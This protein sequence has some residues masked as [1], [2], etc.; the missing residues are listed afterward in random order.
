MPLSRRLARLGWIT[1]WKLASL[2]NRDRFREYRV[3]GHAIHLNVSESLMMYQIARGEYESHKLRVLDRLLEGGGTFVDVGANTGIFAFY[4]ATRVGSA[5]RIIAVEPEPENCRWI[6]AGI[7]A[8][9][10]AQVR[11][12]AGGLSDRDGEATLHLAE[13]SGWHTLNPGQRKRMQGE[14]RVQT[15]TLDSIAADLDRLD[16]VKIDVEGHEHAV[17]AG[18]TDS[19]P[20][21]RPVILLD[22][23]PQLGADRDRIEGLLAEWGYGIEY[24]KDSGRQID[25]LPER[26]AELLLEPR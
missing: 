10:F 26:P 3:N 25:R 22:W 5:G 17:L 4:A 21:F 2:R 15:W 8:N 23:H 18:A 12:F 6:R 9:G 1:R 14:L 13:K 19:V 11:L 7:E 16:C 24:L 20:R